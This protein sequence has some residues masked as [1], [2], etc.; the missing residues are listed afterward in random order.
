MKKTWKIILITA[1]TLAAILLAGGWYLSVH[2]KKLLDAELRKY[3]AEGSDSLYTLA[4]GKINMNL[5]TGS[6]AIDHVAL[7]PDSAVYEKL[8]AEQ[9]A[10]EVLYNARLGRVQV[11]GLRIWRYFLHKEVDATS[12]RLRDPELTIV[13]DMRSHDTTPRKN[14][15]QAINKSI[16]QFNIS[17]IELA[18]TSVNFTQI[19]EDS[20]R[21]ITR[22]GN[23]DVTLRNLVI[24]SISQ[25][26]LSRVLY[27]QD[28]TVGLRKWEYRTPDSLYWLRVTD[29]SYN[30]VAKKLTVGSLK[31]DPRYNKAQFD[32][33]IRTQKDRFELTFN[34][35]SAEGVHL[36]HI[37]Q[38][39]A[40]ISK[41]SI[42]GGSLHVYRNRGLPMPPGD[43]YGQFPNQ[44]LMK[45]EM[46]LQIEALTAQG[47]NVTYSE[48]N[49]KN[50]ETGVIE[51]HQAGGTF[52]HISNIDSSVKK[53]PHATIDLHAILMRT[54]KLRAHF[55]FTLGSTTGVFAV[56]GKLN[57]MDG[58]DM[59]PATRPLGEV[60][61]RSA[62]IREMEF[63]I[64]GNERSA[65]GTLTM[66]YD[67]LKIEML[68]DV[69][70]K[71]KKRKKG[72]I[73]LIANL[74][75]LHNE[76]P[77]P[78][79]PLRVAKPRFARDPQKSFF[80]LVWKTIFTGIKETVLTDIGAGALN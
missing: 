60:A 61:I 49:P 27:A 63:N 40:I 18:N 37:L 38:Q 51:F 11:T 5:L 41:A 68:K 50:G 64:R 39:Q 73:S 10:P 23:L 29:V 75:A 14:F 71:G 7:L 67:D 1:G 32:K 28:F 53:N 21:K 56:S 4:Y 34:K 45:L 15:Y 62:R 24:D 13:H 79:Q 66:K 17:V 55:D 54:G 70:A 44:L 19:R 31:L 77:S 57:D 3:V 8:V 52:R 46:P 2:W 74:M 59:N 65:A 33:Q 30:A 80:N 72:L 48:V 20:S 36:G 16:R 69:E 42:D 76:N 43:K 25:N 35:I 22:L 26:D 47:V 6:V 58:K 12:F 78:G 9:R